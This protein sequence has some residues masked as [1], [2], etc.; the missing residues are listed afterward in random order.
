MT[1]FR[2]EADASIH[3]LLETAATRALDDAG[4]AGQDLDS[5]HVGNMA[6]EAFNS[7]SG[8]HNALTASLGAHGARRPTASRTRAR[9]AP[10]RSCAASRPSPR[11]PRTPPSWSA[12]S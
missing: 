2:S 10:A 5:V 6:S 11:A 3:D 12:A 8:L 1:R 7:R 4:V 9:A